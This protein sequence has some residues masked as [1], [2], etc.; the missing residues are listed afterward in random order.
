MQRGKSPLGFSIE[1]TSATPLPPGLAGDDP[2]DD[3][4]GA[5]AAKEASAGPAEKTTVVALRARSLSRASTSGDGG[6]DVDPFE[7]STE[8]RHV[9]AEAAAQMLLS[10]PQGPRSA[11]TASFT[12]AGSATS[13]GV[14]EKQP[15]PFRKPRKGSI[16][17][18]KAAERAKLHAERMRA[19]RLGIKI[20]ADLSHNVSTANSRRG[21][22]STR[23]P[24]QEAS[25]AITPYGS[26]PASRT[27]SRPVSPSKAEAVSVAKKFDNPEIAART[28]GHLARSAAALKDACGIGLTFNL[29]DPATNPDV[30]EVLFEV[31]RALAAASDAAAAGVFMG[32]AAHRGGMGGGQAQRH[33]SPHRSTESGAAA[34]H[35]MQ[36]PRIPP[37][38]APRAPNAQKPAG[39]S[40]ARSTNNWASLK[41]VAGASSTFGRS[42]LTGAFT[43]RQPGTNNAGG[44]MLPPIGRR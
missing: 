43:A 25:C 33:R 17:R 31:M 1:V 8:Q 11:S 27:P 6:G 19:A 30:K 41:N 22:F 16:M 14:D 28:I 37:L 40:T 18:S 32:G 7:M 44:G 3:D 2:G 23:M 39:A 38:P 12:S 15:A 4:V 42:P 26:A 13:G 24:G 21:S 10:S 35:P 9:A 34:S 29:P 36:R 20:S 5:A